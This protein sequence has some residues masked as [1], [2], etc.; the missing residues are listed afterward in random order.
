[1]LCKKDTRKLSN[2]PKIALKYFLCHATV[3]AQ[4]AD[5][6]KGYYPNGFTGVYEI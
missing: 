6:N 3:F 1:M 4:F 2:N 5:L